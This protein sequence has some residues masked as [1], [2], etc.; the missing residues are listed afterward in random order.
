MNEEFTV[1]IRMGSE[2]MDH[3]TDV[4]DAL[5]DVAAALY[6]GQTGGVINDANGDA[7]GRFHMDHPE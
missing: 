4:A 6:A 3:P 7:V 1:V 5:R 2:D